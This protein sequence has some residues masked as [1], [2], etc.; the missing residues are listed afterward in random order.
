MA[1]LLNDLTSNLKENLLKIHAKVHKL[2]EKSLKYELDYCESIAEAV[3]KDKSCKN[4]KLDKYRLLQIERMWT[5][6]FCEINQVDIRLVHEHPTVK[7]QI[8]YKK[9]RMKKKIHELVEKRLTRLTD[10]RAK[11]SKPSGPVIEEEFLLKNKKKKLKPTFVDPKARV[12][13]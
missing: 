9:S 5:E 12:R 4:G 6:Y 3:F 2:N 11:R 13:P 10:I 8:R 7:S 1:A